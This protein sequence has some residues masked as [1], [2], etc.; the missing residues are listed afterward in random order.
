M[1]KNHTNKEHHTSKEHHNGEKD[2][3][4]SIQQHSAQHKHPKQPDQK[5]PDENSSAN[6][7]S[8]ETSNAQ[9]PVIDENQLIKERKR[10][11]DEIRNKGIEPYPYS[12]NAKNH[13]ADIQEKHKSLEKEEKT[14]EKVKVAGRLMSLR[15]M[16][17][18]AFANLLD[19]TGKV[20]L[21][22]R[23]DSLGK[24]HYKLLKLYDIGDIIGAE[25]TVFKTRTGEVTIDVHKFELLT[26]TLRPMPEKFHGLKD[27]ETRYRQRYLDLITSP[28]SKKVF[29]ARSNII[30][31]IREFM[32]THEFME[33]ETPTL[34]AIYGGASAKPFITQHNALN[35]QFYMRISPELYLKRLIVGGYE[36]V[37]EICKNF[38]NEG[39][40]IRH[41]PEFTM[42]EMY[43]AYA[44]Y[45][46]MMRFTE[47][48]Y[49]H[50]AKKV[51]GK[52]KITYQG[53]EIDFKTPWQR[54]TMKEAIKKY[55]DI[56]ID[57]LSDDELK[58]IMTNY[59]IEY[60]GG[61]VRGKAIQLIFEELC[62][63]KLFEPVFIIDHPKESTPLCKKHRKNPE[64]VERFEPYIAGME[65]GN[66]YSELNDP[67]EQREKLVSQAKARLKGDED[68]NPMD[69][70]FV[71]AI[72]FGMPP[73]GGVGIGIDRM[74]MI[75]TDQASIRDV[76]LFPTLKPEKE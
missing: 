76:I 22:F 36:R 7:Q 56:E 19:T 24:D 18:A 25:G 37:F 67:I 31:A 53:K 41:N 74:V 33:V 71:R 32:A 30:L 13:A 61:F 12:Y 38:R 40:D 59:N 9:A 68:A 54:L 58:K 23:E 52:T 46:D 43:M 55:A 39:I 34:Q 64:L 6:N 27:T 73:T 29:E 49:N 20:Q 69:E 4:H 50:V 42:M 62:E 15:N 1:E 48:L 3:G 2:D 75:L 45:D 8:H 28:E 10:K 65:I 35:T 16:G 66:G 72:E 17:K 60:E 44:D 14:D 11:L 47:Q 5:Q 70:D 51:L 57:S 21:F 26:K 63:D